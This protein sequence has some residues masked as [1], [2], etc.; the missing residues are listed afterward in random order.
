MH[1]HKAFFRNAVPAIRIGGIPCK[2]ATDL[3]IDAT[4]DHFI[5]A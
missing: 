4:F 1:Y 3:V 5:K 2:T